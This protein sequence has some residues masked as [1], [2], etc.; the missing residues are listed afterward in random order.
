M[1]PKIRFLF[2]DPVVDIRGNAYKAMINLA[3]FTFGIDNIIN[4]NIVAVLINKLVEEK[5]DEI[6][7]LILELMQVLL[8]GEN[9]SLVVQGSDILKHL[10]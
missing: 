4:F 8:H 2:D 9:S 7:I 5:S 1:I 6:L 10:N 3:E